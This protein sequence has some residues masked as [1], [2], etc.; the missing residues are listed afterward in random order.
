MFPFPPKAQPIL[1]LNLPP[2]YLTPAAHQ[3]QEAR[4]NR[5]RMAMIIRVSVLVS[6]LVAGLWF[7]WWRK[8]KNAPAKS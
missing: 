1:K 6:V 4:Q 2:E 5:A 3:A 8:R 7:F